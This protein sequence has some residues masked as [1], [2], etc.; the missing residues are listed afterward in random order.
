[1]EKKLRTR[2]SPV[3]RCG[4]STR[5]PPSLCYASLLRGSRRSSLRGGEAK[6]SEL[7]PLASAA[8]LPPASLGQWCDKVGALLLSGPA[9]ARQ[10]T[11]PVVAGGLPGGAASRWPPDGGC[12]CGRRA[13]LRSSSTSARRLPRL[14]PSI[15]A[16]SESLHLALHQVCHAL[17]S[18]CSIFR[19]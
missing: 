6:A 16:T 18:R 4:S 9:S 8:P 2:E 15:F 12:W 7:L 10:T 17:L 11:V 3:P 14:R 5:S 13:R 1:L 19:D